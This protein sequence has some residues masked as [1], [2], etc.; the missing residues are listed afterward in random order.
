MRGQ[1]GSKEKN[2]D[3]LGNKE[4]EPMDE[5]GRKKKPEK[6]EQALME[7]IQQ[8]IACT[9]ITPLGRDRWYRRF[10]TFFSVPGLLVEEDYTGITEDMLQPRPASHREPEM[11]SAVNGHD[12]SVQEVK[13]ESEDSKPVNK[14]NRWC[15]YSSVEQLEQLIE[16]LNTRGHRES[17]LKDT[18]VQEKPRICQKLSN[19]SAECFN[20]SG[21]S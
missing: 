11:N 12:S 15:Y 20:I 10:W 17:T 3:S 8:V 18:L 5:G 4:G 16:N 13:E 7:K 21:I 19:F 6:R 2:R 1:N 14:P 9:N